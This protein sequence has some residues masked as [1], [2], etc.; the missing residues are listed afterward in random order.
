MD[1]GIYH[2]RLIE[3][4]PSMNTKKDDIKFM[5]KRNKDIPS[6]IPTKPILLLKIWYWDIDVD[7]VYWRCRFYVWNNI[8]SYISECKC[9]MSHPINQI[10]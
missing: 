4:A 2:S 3:K 1:N 9:Q 7:N 5:V 8:W 10:N 6:S